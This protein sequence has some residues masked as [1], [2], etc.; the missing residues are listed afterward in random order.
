VKILLVDDDPD[1]ARYLQ[2]ALIR[3]QDAHVLCIEPAHMLAHAV[4]AHRPDVGGRGHGLVRSCARRDFW[5][6][7]TGPGGVERNA[8]SGVWLN[9]GVLNKA[10][11][12]SDVIALVVLWRLVCQ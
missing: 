8:L 9:A 6:A 3:D 10:Q 4:I 2:R 12:P 5:Q 1:R 11:Y 7:L